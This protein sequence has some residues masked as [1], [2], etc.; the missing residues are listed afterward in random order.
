MYLHLILRSKGA[1]MKETTFIT[2]HPSKDI[3]YLINYDGENILKGLNFIEIHDIQKARQIAGFLKLHNHIDI[4]ILSRERRIIK[5]IYS[6]FPY[7]RLVYEP[8]KPFTDIDKLTRELFNLGSFTICLDSSYANQTTIRELQKQGISVL[9]RVENDIEAY[10]ATLAGADGVLGKQIEK[11]HIETDL[12]FR[13]FLVSHRGHQANY[14]ENSLNA[15][16][17]A[18]NIGA[19][20]I[21]LDIHMTKNNVIVVNHGPS[22]GE[23]YDKDYAIKRNTFKELKQARQIFNGQPTDDHIESLIH[24][25]KAIKD[26]VG[27]ILDIKVDTKRNI[28]RIARMI[29]AMKRP[30]YVMSFLPFA[31]VRIN[32]YANRVKSGMLLSFHEKKLTVNSLLK[33]VHKY[34][35]VVHPYFLHDS[36]KYKEALDKRMIPMVPYGLS[37]TDTY[38]VFKQGYHMVNSDSIDTLIHLPKQLMTEKYLH[39]TIGEYTKIILTDEKHNKLD[40]KAEILFGNPNGLVIDN[41][42][43]TTADKAGVSYIYLTHT[44]EVNGEP[45][46]YTSDLITITIHE[47]RGDRNVDSSKSAK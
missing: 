47:K 6:I 34:N 32:R 1:I 21:E 40:F 14:I 12:Y 37:K 31:I 29:D 16:I 36:P 35:L 45:I 13:P 10:E 46:T 44:T 27:F 15:A 7:V 28:R 3:S 11:V 24:F 8:K 39:Y 38:Q 18:E 9:I 33:L 20:F 2:T 19:E 4:F 25:D 23:N 43:I 26:D 42:G 22:L 17:A 5:E 30:V 41:Q